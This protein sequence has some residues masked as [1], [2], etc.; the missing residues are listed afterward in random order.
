MNQK[1]IYQTDEGGVAVLIPSPE[2]LEQYGIEAIALKDVPAGKPFKIVDAADIPTNRSERNAWEVDEALLTD[3][4]GADYGAG[5]E[6][7]V[8]DLDGDGNPDVL[9]NQRTGEIKKVSEQ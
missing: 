1:I 6:W 3:G 7:A 2:A 9:V 5:S 8:V 4:V